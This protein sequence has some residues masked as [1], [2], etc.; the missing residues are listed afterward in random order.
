MFF[1]W[2]H[3]LAVVVVKYLSKMVSQEPL[4]LTTS[5]F[6]ASHNTSKRRLLREDG[7]SGT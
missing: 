4:P 7:A 6:P 1:L 5:L 3:F 2:G